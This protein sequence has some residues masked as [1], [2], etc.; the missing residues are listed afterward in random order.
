MSEP[1][2]LEAAVAAL[3][4]I[5]DARTVDECRKILETSNDA[6]WNTAAVRALGAVGAQ[7][8]TPKFLEMVSDF[9]NPLAPAALIALGDLHEPKT[10]AKL[11]DALS[12]RREEVVLAAERAAGQLAPDDAFRAR[13]AAVLS[14]SAASQSTRAAALDAL[15]ALKDAHLEKALIEAA[16]DAS[17]EQTELLGRI[18]QILRER[19]IAIE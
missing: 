19:K 16:K 18:D 3:A 11:D 8:F 5:K 9:K 17:L 12:S 14:D 1:R 2:L 15:I 10:L 4:A 7:E 13:L 6:G